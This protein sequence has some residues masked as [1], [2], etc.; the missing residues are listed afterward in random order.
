D[1]TALMVAKSAPTMT[2]GELQTAAK[3]YFQAMFQSADAV[4]SEITVSY[5]AAKSTVN[6]DGTSKVKTDFVSIMGKQFD[7]LPITGASSVSWG[8]S[9]LR[10]A[11]ALD[12]TGSMA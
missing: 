11:L 12:N 1:A 9:R 6:I 2:S 8:N 4:T 5:D 7:T 10:V 3:A